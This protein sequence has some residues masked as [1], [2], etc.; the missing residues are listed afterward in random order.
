MV[1]KAVI[2]LGGNLGDVERQLRLALEALDG[3]CG[4]KLLRVSPFYRTAAVEVTEPQ[5][6]YLNCVAE[7]ET[8]LSPHALL[9][10]CLGI[11]S[12]LGRV[13]EGVKSPRTVDMDLLLY[14]GVSVESE[15]LTV[16]HP[17][18]LYRAFVLV[19]LRDLYP[20]EIAL[21]VDFAEGFANIAGQSIA[22]N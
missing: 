21:G 7:I 14:E 17:R 8:S 6:D 2:G 20:G 3:L 4:T 12:A 9:G 15:E 22:P 19:P 1:R 10:A 18:L 5:P 13:R 16:P 11:E